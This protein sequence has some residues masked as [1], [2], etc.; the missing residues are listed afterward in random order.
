MPIYYC[1]KDFIEPDKNIIWDG[2]LN[3][4]KELVNKM[5]PFIKDYPAKKYK[6]SPGN[7]EITYRLLLQYLHVLKLI[8][9]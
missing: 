1:K 6:L 4:D 7:N 2:M 9:I 5:N 3:W 8:E